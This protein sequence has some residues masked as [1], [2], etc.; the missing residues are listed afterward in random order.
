[1]L[2]FACKLTPN[3]AGYDDGDGD[4]GLAQLGGSARKKRK[5]YDTMYEESS[6]RSK[7][8]SELTEAVKGFISS[9]KAE[10][11]SNPDTPNAKLQEMQSLTKERAELKRL[12]MSDEITEMLLNSIEK[13]LVQIQPN[14]QC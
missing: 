4:A 14:V 8:L 5:F 1:M 11:L 12:Q 3:G 13:R 10:R 9:Q 6:K 7:S 2:N